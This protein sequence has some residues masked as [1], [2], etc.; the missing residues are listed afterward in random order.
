[1]RVVSHRTVALCAD[2][3][4]EMFVCVIGLWIKHELSDSRWCMYGVI[5]RT[6]KD[7]ILFLHYFLFLEKKWIRF[8]IVHCIHVDL[9]PVYRYLHSTCVDNPLVESTR[10]LYHKIQKQNLLYNIRVK[11]KKFTTLFLFYGEINLY[12]TVFPIFFITVEYHLLRFSLQ[13]LRW[14]T[15]RLFWN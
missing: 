2:I 14:C 15:S 3:S 7:T 8:N 6:L 12:S 1:M 13:S 9:T 4:Q 11:H 5:M 10:N